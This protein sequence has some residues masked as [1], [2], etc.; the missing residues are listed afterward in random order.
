MNSCCLSITSQFCSASDRIIT[1]KVLPNRPYSVRI[2]R[3][4]ASHLQIS[5]NV[6][7]HG[8]SG[9]RQRIFAPPGCH[10]PY[11]TRSGARSHGARWASHRCGSTGASRRNRGH[12]R[13]PRGSWTVPVMNQQCV[14]QRINA[15]LARNR[16]GIASSK[17]ISL[18]SFQLCINLPLRENDLSVQAIVASVAMH[19]IPAQCPDVPAE[20]QQARLLWIPRQQLPPFRAPQSLKFCDLVARF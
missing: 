14:V 20:V 11:H 8:P 9:I 19:A 12:R 4:R 1:R 5:F 3:R 6:V 7:L 16:Q 13:P 15:R 2:A 17:S 10:R 18:A